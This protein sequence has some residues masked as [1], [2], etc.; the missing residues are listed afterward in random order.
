[1]ALIECQKLTKRFGGLVALKEVDLQL[2]EGEVLGLIGPNGSGKTTLINCVTGFYRPTAGKVIFNGKD[3]TGQNN[4]EICRKGLART[5]QIPRPFP[6]LT[7]LEN[8]VVGSRG[9][10]EI[11]LRSLEEV[12]LHSMKD[13]LAKN[14]TTHQTR[15]LEVARAMAT[16]PKVLLLDEVMAGLNPVEIEET[17]S[18]LGKVR[19]GGLTLLWVEHVMRAI[20]KAADRLVVLH[21][22]KKIA[23]G[24]PSEIASSE[25]VV[26]AYLGERY[27]L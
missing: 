25:K 1:M 15:M 19:E 6:R 18:L 3:I 17:I 4:C 26:E 10:R 2:N 11:A 22:G 7:V 14:L 9:D 24:M 27:M 23:E 8:V 16:N 21:E 20:M 13:T 12:G 5:F